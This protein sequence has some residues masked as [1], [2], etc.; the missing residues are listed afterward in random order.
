M[1]G[2]LKCFSFFRLS[3]KVCHCQAASLSHFLLVDGTVTVV[4]STMILNFLCQRNGP[5]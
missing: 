3:Q 5:T 2:L 1:E 4:M